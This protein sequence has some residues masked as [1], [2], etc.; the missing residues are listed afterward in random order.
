M[1]CIGDEKRKVF[2]VTADPA[3]GPGTY[4]LEKGSPNKPAYAPFSSLQPKF[5]PTRKPTKQDGV[6]LG[7]G[8]PFP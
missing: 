2:P 1:A 8:P 5:G 6:N 3:V 4:N 7:P